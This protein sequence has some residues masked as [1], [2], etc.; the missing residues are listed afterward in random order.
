MYNKSSL[1]L[2]LMLYFYKK[3]KS[4]YMG[5]VVSCLGSSTL[6]QHGA[7]KDRHGT[8]KD[9]AVPCHATGQGSLNQHG[10]S[11][12]SCYAKQAQSK[13]VNWPGTVCGRPVFTSSV[14]VCFNKIASL[15][16]LFLSLNLI[17]PLFFQ[18]RPYKSIKSRGWCEAT[19]SCGEVIDFFDSMLNIDQSE[20]GMLLVS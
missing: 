13:T 14:M 2:N 3:L 8:I 4:L 15:N 12:G 16:S 5:C 6:A 10:P 1:I 17:F 19:V 11:F 18:I 9:W 7:A 20:K